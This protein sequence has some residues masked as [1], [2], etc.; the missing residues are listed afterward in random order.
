MRQAKS[1]RSSLL[2]GY[3]MKRVLGGILDEQPHP[4]AVA[5]DMARSVSPYFSDRLLPCPVDQM[6]YRQ[7]QRDHQGKH[8]Q[9]QSPP[10]QADTPPQSAALTR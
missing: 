9:Q 7:V 6:I 2:R 1:N 3:R 5:G 8:Q 4:D 10:R